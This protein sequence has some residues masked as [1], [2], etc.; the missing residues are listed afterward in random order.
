MPDEQR[1]RFLSNV[2][3]DAARMERLVT[4]LLQL[5]RIQSAP[6]AAEP[7][8][9]REHLTDL[10]ARYGD[11]VRLHIA[12]D[13]PAA[14]VIHPDHLDAA[15]H[16]LIEN[17]VRHGGG[18]PVE[19]TADAHAGRLRVRV[20]DHGPGV[21][22]AGKEAEGNGHAGAAGPDFQEV[23]PLAN[24]PQAVGGPAPQGL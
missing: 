10:V 8:A 22:P 19:V 16:N 17:A 14:V 9:V 15:L 2:D 7:V 4:R 20:R 23:K 18:A 5:A 1:Q 21:S 11:R 12:P 6:D 3:A 13:A 24:R